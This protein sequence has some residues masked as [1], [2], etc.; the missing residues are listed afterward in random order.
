MVNAGIARLGRMA[1][2]GSGEMSKFRTFEITHLIEHLRIEA[3]RAA[4]GEKIGTV[5]P[6]D[7]LLKDAAD[8]LAEAHA[9]YCAVE[10]ALA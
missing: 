3:Q 7:V 1:M 6:I 2:E 4:S 8:T 9:Y 10:G 5:Q